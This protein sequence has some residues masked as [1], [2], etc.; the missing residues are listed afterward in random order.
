[1]R[2]G[3]RD[4][5]P[6][7]APRA[8]DPRYRLGARTSTRSARPPATSS[9]CRSPSSRLID[10]RP[11]LVQGEMRPRRRERPAG[12][13]LL[14]AHDRER[15]R[16][17]RRTTLRRTRASPTIPSSSAAPHLRFYAG[18]PL[19]YRP[20][21]RLGTL[22]I[23]DFEPRDFSAA[24]DQRGCR[25]SPTSSS[26]TCVSTRPTCA[27]RRNSPRGARPRPPCR[28]R[29]PLPP[30][31]RARE[32]PHRSRPRRRPPLLHLSRRDADARLLAPTR[33]SASA[34]AT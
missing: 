19:I 15:R 11:G 26:R 5:A 27:T 20:G 2:S 31:G 3:R 8:E 32:R 18:A 24:D 13:R 10:E 33:R 6:G 16:P 25:S 30:P 21:L 12:A 29:I 14:Q 17:R 23:I 28:E 9:R 7:R 34:C 1:M 22:C 4:G